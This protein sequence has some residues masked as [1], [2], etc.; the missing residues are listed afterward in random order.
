M[1]IVRAFAALLGALVLTGPA[2]AVVF[3]GSTGSGVVTDYSAPSLASFDL[4][5]ADF[6]SNKLNFVI[7]AD[8][9]LSPFLNLNAVVRNMTGGGIS[10]FTFSLDGISFANAGS[11]TPTFGT[12]SSSGFASDRA[13][14]NFSPAEPAEFHFGNPF[15]VPGKSDWLLNLTGLQAGD[16]FSIRADVPEPAT[17]AMMLVGMSLLGLSS[18]RRRR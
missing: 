12:L 3:T 8:D 18:R 15:G 13:W 16:A 5:L 2:Y 17:L 14:M 6:S 11:I 10:R 4:D 9:L 7:E 1:K